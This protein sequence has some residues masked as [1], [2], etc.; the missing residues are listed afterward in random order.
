M[1]CELRESQE[2]TIACFLGALNKETADMIEHQPFVS[3]KDVIKLAI[4]GQPQG[5]TSHERKM[6]VR[7]SLKLSRPRYFTSE[8]PNWREVTIQN[9]H[10]V[11]S[12]VEEA[13]EDVCGVTSKEK[14]EFADEGEKLKAKQIVSS[15]S[16]LEEQWECLEN[17]PK[18]LISNS[19]KQVLK[20]PILSLAQEELQEEFAIEDLLLVFRPVKPEIPEVH[21]TLLR[22]GQFSQRVDR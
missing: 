3:P 5:G 12:E 10:A 16:K 17:I 8:F 9:P 22:K 4:K 13:V 20:E 15:E 1:G 2:T 14:V 21:M 18:V 7:S 11:E 6:R 19:P